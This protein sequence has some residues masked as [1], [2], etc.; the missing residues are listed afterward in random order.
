MRKLT[1][2]ELITRYKIIHND[3][4]DYSDV[5]YNGIKNTIT[6]ICPK[7]GKFDQIAADHIDGHGCA[8]CAIEKNTIK[9]RNNLQDLI[10]RANKLHNNRYDYSLITSYKSMHDYQNIIC[11]K[12]GIFSIT[13]H[14]HINK[15]RGCKK[16]AI[17]KSKDNKTDFILKSKKI[18]G[19]KYD[20]SKVNYVNSKRC[21]YLRRI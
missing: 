17:D 12:H 20:Y 3:F 8:K 18:H 9:K 1:T 6:I 7:H 4:Y 14:S 5:K 2:E 21:K 16:C 10:N 11:L 13:L 15:S 19:N